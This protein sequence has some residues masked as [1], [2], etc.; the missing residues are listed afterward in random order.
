MAS[1]PLVPT[2]GKLHAQLATGTPPPETDEDL[3]NF[4]E[5]RQSAAPQPALPKNEPAA[6]VPSTLAHVDAP[7]AP[8]PGAAPPAPQAAPAPSAEH[9]RFSMSPLATAL[10]AAVLVANVALMA[11]AWN[12]VNATRDLVLDV[13]HDVREASTDLRN[14]SNQRSAAAARASEPAFGALPEG[15]RTLELARERVAQGE[16]I[17]ARRMLHGLLAVIDRVE[18]PAREEIEARAGFLIADSYRLE[19]DA[20]AR[21]TEQGR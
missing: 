12:S 16:H 6:V 7:S 17:R 20:L 8:T 1:D 5:V 4:V 14:E 9:A 11:F 10:F 13:A 18:Q 2:T 19:A 3:F 15:F 21:N